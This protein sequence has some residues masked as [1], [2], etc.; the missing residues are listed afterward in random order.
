MVL[1]VTLAL[2]RVRHARLLP[3][4]ASHA[5]LTTS[6]SIPQTNVVCQE[7]TVPN[8]VSLSAQYATVRIS[9]RQVAPLTAP[10]CLELTAQSAMLLDA[11]CVPPIYSARVRAHSIALVFL[12]LVVRHVMSLDA[13]N[14]PTDG[15]QFQVQWH[16]QILLTVDLSA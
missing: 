5:S 1:P 15:N 16:A 9:R 4:T 12:E 14:V 6:T 7:L 3:P 10:V 11:Q 2:C 8:A 13:F